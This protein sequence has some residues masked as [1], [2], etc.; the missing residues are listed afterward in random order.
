VIGGRMAD[1]DTPWDSERVQSALDA[2]LAA[3]ESL[4]QAAKA[5]AAVCGWQK[6]DVYALGQEK[7]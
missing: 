1:D 3:G 6:R 2:R 5:V 7:P 4:S